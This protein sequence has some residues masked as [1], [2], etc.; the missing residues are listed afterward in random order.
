MSMAS[1]HFLPPHLLVLNLPHLLQEIAYWILR[2]KYL[3]ACVRVNKTWNDAIT[4][5]L[6]R[7]F[8]LHKR[9]RPAIWI[10]PAIQRTIGISPAIQRAISKNAHHVRCLVTRSTSVFEHLGPD[11]RIRKLTYDVSLRPSLRADE[12]LQDLIQF[13]DKQRWHGKFEAFSTT[14]FPFDSTEQVKSLMRAV[15]ESVQELEIYSS[16]ITYD[17]PES[18]MVLLYSCSSKRHLQALTIEMGYDELEDFQEQHESFTAFWN[19]MRLDQDAMDTIH[20]QQQQ[21]QQKQRHPNTLTLKQL[22]LMGNFQRFEDS[23]LFPLLQF[24]PSLETLNIP[25]IYPD[26]LNDLVTIL[27]AHCPR[28]KGLLLNQNDFS[29]EQVS[30]L[31]D[32]GIQGKLEHIAFSGAEDEIT[33]RRIMEMSELGTQRAL[34]ENAATLA[35]LH[36]HNCGL[37]LTST[38]IQ[39]VL[40]QCSRLK[41]LRITGVITLPYPDNDATAYIPQTRMGRQR[42]VLT[43]LNAMDIRGE[44]WSCTYLRVLQLVIRNV[45]RS[46]TR[47]PLG[48]SVGM[49]GK[50][51]QDMDQYLLYEEPVVMTEAESRT[52]QRQ[53]C[54]RIGALK[55]LQELNLGLFEFYRDDV[56]RLDDVKI[57]TPIQHQCLELSLET[58]LQALADLRELRQLKIQ[59]IGHA[60]G[61]QEIEWMVRQGVWPKLR[62]IN[63]VADE[64]VWTPLGKVPRKSLAK[65]SHWYL[66]AKFWMDWA[67]A[68]DNPAEWLRRQRPNLVVNKHVL[69]SEFE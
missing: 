62:L 16:D 56:D 48:V 46:E 36:L 60:M 69:D 45:P 66:K 3:A 39:Q 10:S 44:P 19:R 18:L 61:A 43:G 25:T 63:G 67:S 41:E 22:T 58:G 57:V 33:G 55:H 8:I 34:L 14:L 1:T 26:R 31:I 30:H 40:V 51:R 23:I 13:L 59:R 5:V 2:P 49:D 53:I 54:Q 47:L 52:V 42:R 29:D 15:P 37:A 64:T 24:C 11:T 35:V 21:Q 17:R 9:S 38:W 6:W 68:R 65:A 28:L 32:S 4:P 20:D 50:Q 27:R 12:S 7:Y